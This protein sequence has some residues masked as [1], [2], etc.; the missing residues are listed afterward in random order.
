MI[1]ASMSLA[2]GRQRIQPRTRKIH[3]ENGEDDKGKLIDNWGIGNL[4]W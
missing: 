1:V 4:S 2:N 3:R